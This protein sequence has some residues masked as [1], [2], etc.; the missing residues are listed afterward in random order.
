[1]LRSTDRHLD[2]STVL[3]GRICRT[4]RD[5]SG[6]WAGAERSMDAGEMGMGSWTTDLVPTRV[7][8]RSERLCGDGLPL[9]AR[10]SVS[11]RPSASG[12]DRE[13]LSR[14]AHLPMCALAIPLE[15]EPRWN[16]WCCGC[17]RMPANQSAHEAE[18]ERRILA[19]L[20]RTED[21][22]RT[23]RVLGFLK[24]RSFS[25]ELSMIVPLSGGPTAALSRVNLRYSSQSREYT[26]V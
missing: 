8:C 22:P 3:N 12:G 20:L 6:Q 26:N 9:D 4:R 1:M 24:M 25:T 13:Q 16:A 11:P 17:A 7:A 5:L 10:I 2:D 19:S 14:S 21:P 23:R 18:F 15:A